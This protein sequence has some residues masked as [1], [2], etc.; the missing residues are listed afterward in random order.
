VARLFAA[1]AQDARL[2]PEEWQARLPADNPARARAIADFIAGMSDRFAMQ[3]C[4]AIYGVQPA[5][6]INV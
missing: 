5:G 6:L 2:M 4:A 1:Y 3:Q